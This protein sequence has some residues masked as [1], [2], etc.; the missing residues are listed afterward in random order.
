V[1]CQGTFDQGAKGVVASGGVFFGWQNIEGSFFM[2]AMF[3][4]TTKLYKK[5]EFLKKNTHKLY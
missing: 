5:T 2:C 1:Q 3:R 4:F